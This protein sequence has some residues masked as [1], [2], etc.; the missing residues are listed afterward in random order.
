MCAGLVVWG[1]RLASVSVS[2]V[3]K[4]CLFSTFQMVWVAGCVI[5]R[6]PTPFKNRPYRHNENIC[7]QGF[8]TS[9][10]TLYVTPNVPH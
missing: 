10:T 3:L 5:I 1:E 8:S 2:F 6:A 7:H 9:N 4:L